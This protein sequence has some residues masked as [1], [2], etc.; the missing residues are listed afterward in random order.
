MVLT[1]RASLMAAPPTHTKD[2]NIAKRTVVERRRH[3]APYQAAPLTLP[4]GAFVVNT[5]AVLLNAGF[6]AAPTRWSAGSR[7]AG[8]MVE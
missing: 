6:Q 1:E 2:F 3:R 5:V 7:P 8:L 4:T